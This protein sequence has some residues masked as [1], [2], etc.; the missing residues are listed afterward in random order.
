MQMQHVLSGTQTVL[1]NI[2]YKEFTLQK[3]KMKMIYNLH[4]KH[5]FFLNMNSM[6]R[7]SSLSMLYSFKTHSIVKQH[8]KNL[9]L[10]MSVLYLNSVVLCVFYLNNNCAQ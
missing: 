6:H 9:E 8:L 7:H 2:I 5:F 4:W 3:V 1:V 10:L